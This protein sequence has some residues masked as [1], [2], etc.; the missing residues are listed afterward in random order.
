MSEA[1]IRKSE[2]QAFWYAVAICLVPLV[3]YAIIGQH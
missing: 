2:R 3:P 1:T